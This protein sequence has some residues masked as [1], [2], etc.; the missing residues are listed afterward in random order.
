MTSPAYY[1]H[2]L[3]R[4]LLAIEVH[5]PSSIFERKHWSTLRWMRVNDQ[6]GFR[7]IIEALREHGMERTDIVDVIGG[8]EHS[9]HCACWQCVLR[10]YG[11]VAQ[12]QARRQVR[13]TE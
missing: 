1:K 10:L 2:A 8:D 6:Q 12:A 7:W 4:L 3:E 5:G 11:Q 9:A 13:A